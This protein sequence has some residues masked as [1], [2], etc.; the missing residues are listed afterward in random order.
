MSLETVHEESS[1]TTEKQ[2]Q[3]EKLKLDNLEDITFQVENVSPTKEEKYSSEYCIAC[4]DHPANIMLLP[5]EHKILCGYCVTRL[6]D[7]LCPFCRNHV[8]TVRIFPR[9]HA[10]FT[11]QLEEKLE[12]KKGQD[13]EVEDSFREASLREESFSGLA[14]LGNVSSYSRSPSLHSSH[15]IGGEPSSSGPKRSVS[16]RNFK[17]IF[18]TPRASQKKEPKEEY[19][20][21]KIVV[22]LSNIL[23]E[24]KFHENEVIE[25]TF[26]VLVTGSDDVDKE[27]IVHSL[28]DLFPVKKPYIPW[29]PEEKS[30][31]GHEEYLD[32]IDTFQAAEDFVANLDIQGAP[33]RVTA[34]N[35]WELLRIMRTGKADV[36]HPDVVILSCDTH[37][38]R[39]FREMLAL[40]EVLRERLKCTTPRFWAVLGNETSDPSDQ[41]SL[42]DAEFA[43]K[44]IPLDRRPQD[45]FFLPERGKFCS[46]YI[47]L[48]K[49]IITHAKS[50]R[51]IVDKNETERLEDHVGC[52]GCTII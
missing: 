2:N 19:I 48:G 23:E 18:T 25:K 26:Q 32:A 34:V 42:E 28:Q 39:S 20:P 31:L 1:E 38:L 15:S 27:G 16:L 13:I 17:R 44:E 14:A 7:Q 12:Q 29:S 6:D 33:V 51:G 41:I 22:S 24:C 47:E 43:F 9:F 45:F 21:P 36:R 49:E 50:A 5:C 40:D 46:W 52:L 8:E 3:L 30:K 35:L 37:S 11:Q 10:G 4:Y